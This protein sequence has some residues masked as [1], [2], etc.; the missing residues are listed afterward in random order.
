MQ[1]WMDRWFLRSDLAKIFGN[2]VDL[3]TP[4]ETQAE[5]HKT[6]DDVEPRFA[7][8]ERCVLKG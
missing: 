6:V 7:I 8:L 3:C 4:V 1:K 5:T 2:R